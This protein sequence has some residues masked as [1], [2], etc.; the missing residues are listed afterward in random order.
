MAIE[1]VTSK[2]QEQQI[3]EQGVDLQSSDVKTSKPE[4]P[5][6]GGVSVRVV[7]GSTTDLEKLVAMLKN[8]NEATRQ[9]VAERRTAILSTVLDSMAERISAAEKENILKLEQLTTEKSEATAQ[10][11][12]LNKDQAVM[13]ALI[14]SLD[15]RIKQAVQDGE[16]HREL[17]EK[18]KA[19]RAEAQ[20]KLDGVK[21]SIKSVSSKIAGIDG[22]IAEC[23]NAIASSTLTEVYAA[24]RAA[25]GDDLLE[26]ESTES[27]AARDKQEAKRV[28]FDVALHISAALDKLDGQIRAALDEAQMKVEG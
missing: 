26:A 20:A 25:T 12:G 21:Q 15:D 3:L 27:Q 4:T 9:S 14:K 18:L 7:D 22:K 24:L 28:A 6:L 23:S 2:I 11:N 8:E 17:V 10:L 1:S 13:E 5:I 19:Q 16:D